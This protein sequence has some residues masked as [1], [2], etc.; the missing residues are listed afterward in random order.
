VLPD[1]GTIA[2]LAGF[3]DQ[4]VGFCLG[5]LVAAV[6]D[7]DSAFLSEGGCGMEGAQCYPVTLGFEFEGVAGLEMKFVS[8]GLGDDDPSG[9]VQ[10]YGHV[11]KWHYKMV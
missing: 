1:V 5:K 10:G 6:K 2:L 9:L 7:P 3:V 11:H 8:K 4:L